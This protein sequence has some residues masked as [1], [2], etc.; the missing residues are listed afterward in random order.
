MR[1]NYTVQAFVKRSRGVIT[2][3]VVIFA[4][5]I[6]KKIPTKHRKV[7]RSGSLSHS[8]CFVYGIKV[9]CQSP[10]LSLK[11]QNDLTV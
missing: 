5:C 2:S 4:V 10:K 6:G 9:V 1:F 7:T 11:E 3:P 8:M